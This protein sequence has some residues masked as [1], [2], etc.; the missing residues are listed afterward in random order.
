ML[1]ACKRVLVSGGRLV[2]DV[3]SVPVHLAGRPDLDGDYGFVATK[4]S[5][6]DL[7]AEAGFTGIGV[8]DTTPGYIA[9]AE[10]WLDAVGDL[11]TDL[12]R[13]LGDDVLED[14]V[15]SRRS[16]YE[17]LLAGELSRTLYWATG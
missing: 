4:E 15:A 5:Y 14:K 13:A 6:E 8:T 7:L 12:R 10:R 11:E 3:V 17:M 2:F 16:S 1:R 9:V